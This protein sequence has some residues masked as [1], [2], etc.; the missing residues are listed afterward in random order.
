[1]DVSPEQ[2]IAWGSPDPGTRRILPNAYPSVFAVVATRSH[3]DYDLEKFQ[4]S[5][6][7]SINLGL[8]Y[9]KV[10]NTQIH[11]PLSGQNR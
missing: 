10:L 9:Q 4:T 11:H 6:N 7:S 3:I 1:M 5:S 2:E 8:I